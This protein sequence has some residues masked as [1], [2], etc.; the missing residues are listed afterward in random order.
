MTNAIKHSRA[1]RIELRCKNGE[2]NKFIFSVVDNG[3]GMSENPYKD[4]HYGLSTMQERTK[5][6]DGELDISAVNGSGTTVS[7]TFIPEVF[8]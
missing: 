7:L 1:N 3:I 5:L 2:N 8:C 6:V 4:H